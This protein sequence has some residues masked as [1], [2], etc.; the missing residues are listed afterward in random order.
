MPSERLEIRISASKLLIAMLVLITPL[1]IAGLLT[2]A[3]ADRSL[4]N[5]VGS[6]FKTIAE[7]SAA[8]VSQYIHDRVTD[9]GVMAMETSIID[10]VTAAN[11]A[12]STRSDAVVAAGIQ[13]IEKA[14]NTTAGE[15]VA[16]KILG[17]RASQMLRRQRDFDRRF[18]RITVTDAKG[19]TVAATHKTLDYYQAD[20]EFWLNV[21]ASGRGAVGI[22]DILYDDVTKANYIG[23]GVPILEEGTNRFLGVLDAL[24][25]VSS[26]FA[27]VHRMQFGPTA[28]TLLVKDDGTVIAG[29]GV[30][31]AMN[32]RSDE[33]AAVSDRLRTIAG[34]ETGYVSANMSGGRQIIGFA[35]AGLKQDYGN[36]AWL[37]LVS[38]NAREAFGPI[39][40]VQ[41]MLGFMS[42]VGLVCVTLLGVYVYLHRR[43]AYTDLDEV[44]HPLGEGMKSASA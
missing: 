37:V 30:N 34:R 14:W 41:R 12:Y 16:Q 15:P 4:E 7:N 1:C 36:L 28:R 22:T 31:L 29:P 9:V 35:D 21:Y 11:S 32:V 19:A 39:R 6:H 3:Q 8:E 13:D 20:E 25:D 5:T 10:A 38:Q 23:I 17:S 18:L 27:A 24:V 33:Y 42:L 43:P 40:N 26:V 2:L 44:E